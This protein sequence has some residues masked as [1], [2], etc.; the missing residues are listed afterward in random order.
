MAAVEMPEARFR[1]QIK[2]VLRKR[3]V[4]HVIDARFLGS[5]EPDSL[6]IVSIISTSPV[7]VQLKAWRLHISARCPAVATIVVSGVRRGFLEARFPT[8]TTD[9]MQANAD[10]YR[11]AHR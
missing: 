9:Q 8:F 2:V 1:E 5:I 3:T 6:R 7:S 10:I 4:T 11:R